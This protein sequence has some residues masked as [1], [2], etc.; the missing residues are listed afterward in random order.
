MSLKLK[1]IIFSLLALLVMFISL[2]L[3][4]GYR[5]TNKRLVVIVSLLNEIRDSA[6]EIGAEILKDHPDLDKIKLKIDGMPEISRKFQEAS[7]SKI[8]P[9][10]YIDVEISFVRVGRIMDKITHGE[11]IEKPILRQIHNETI[12]IE[13]T[14]GTL[15]ALSLTQIDD[16]QSGAEKMIWG[17]YLLLVSYVLGTIMFLTRMVIGP[18]L[19]LSRQ[20]AEIGEGTRT[21]IASFDRGDEIG[22]LSDF[23]KKAITDLA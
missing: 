12:R 6:Y 13:E 18:I 1:T 16:L 2:C 17:F 5:T 10:H 11:L 9:A 22:T 4:Q 21:T 7:R 20:V 14:A 15:L 23:I 3:F 8:K 19:L